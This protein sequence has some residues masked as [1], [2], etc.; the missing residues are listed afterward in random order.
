M[1]ADQPRAL[2]AYPLLA[3]RAVDRVHDRPGGD[4]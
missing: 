1:D 2:V 4:L 3:D